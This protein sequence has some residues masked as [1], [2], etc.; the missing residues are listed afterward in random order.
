MIITEGDSASNAK[1]DK[2]YQAVLGIRGKIRNVFE[3]TL[4]EALKNEE[5]STIIGSIGAGVGS[6]CDPEQ[7][8]YGAG[9][10]S[11]LTRTTTEHTSIR[12]SWLYSTNSC[13]ILS[14]REKFI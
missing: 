2:R 7:S 3:L 9:I 12:C 8:N 13:E 4:S 1:R 14:L 5:V 10:Y 11:L 6:E